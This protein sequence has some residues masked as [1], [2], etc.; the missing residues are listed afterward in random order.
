MTPR[1]AICLSLF[2]AVGWG[3]QPP[4][5]PPAAAATVS[6]AAPAPP[7]A[8]HFA[9]VTAV[10]HERLDSKSC[11][12]GKEFRSAITS[13]FIFSGEPVE[14][15]A[16]FVGHIQACNSDE[17]GKLSMA[18]VVIDSLS[19]P[20]GRI[21]PIAAILQALGPPLPPPRVVATGSD[22][23]Y[24]P[25]QEFHQDIRMYDAAQNVSDISDVARRGAS[26]VGVLD[27]TSRGV[28]GLKHVSFDNTAAGKFLLWVFA[29]ESDPLDIKAGSQLVVRFRITPPPPKGP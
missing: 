14:S 24:V 23:G 21:V 11:S 4:A 15:G 6:P 16:E 22:I 17:S 8:V 20:R 1:F 3:Q 29:A 9:T 27:G 28:V 13:S 19:V 5:S 18:V 10:T 2:A 25:T 7:A 12:N 26:N